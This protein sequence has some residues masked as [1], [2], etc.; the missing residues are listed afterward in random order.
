MTSPS[1]HC[2]SPP[3]K[4]NALANRL[5]LVDRSTYWPIGTLRGEDVESGGY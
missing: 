1:R 4:Y 3:T 5:D 2:Y